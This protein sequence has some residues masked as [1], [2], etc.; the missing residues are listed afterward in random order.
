MTPTRASESGEGS[1]GF[2][3]VNTVSRWGRQLPRRFAMFP[4]DVAVY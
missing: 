3:S 4:I 2:E 1:T